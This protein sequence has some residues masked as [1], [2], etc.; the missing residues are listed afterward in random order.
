MTGGPGCSSMLALFAEN[1]PYNVN[2]ETDELVINPYSW[3]SA[4]ADSAMSV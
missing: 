2:N 3:N 1:G 4:C